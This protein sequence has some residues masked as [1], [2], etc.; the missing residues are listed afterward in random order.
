MGMVA[1]WIII[2]L[3]IIRKKIA[4]PPFTLTLVKQMCTSPPPINKYCPAC[5]I[6]YTISGVGYNRQC[7]FIMNPRCFI[8]PH[9]WCKD[10]VYHKNGFYYPM[11]GTLYYTMSSRNVAFMAYLFR[12]WAYWTW[13][14]A[15]WWFISNVNFVIIPK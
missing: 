2:L 6:G 7:C 5:C 11:N 3:V 4:C 9:K 10:H 13:W 12:I 8:K 1:T 15:F 14:A